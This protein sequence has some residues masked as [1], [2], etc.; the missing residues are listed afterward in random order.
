MGKK[1]NY[2][3]SNNKLKFFIIIVFFIF[4]LIVIITSISK[5]KDDKNNQEKIYIRS[6]NFSTP[7][8]V[9]EYYENEYLSEKTL[10]DDKYSL[11]IYTKFKYDLYEKEESNEEFFYKIIDLIADVLNYQNFK[12]I[13]D[14]K[15]ITIK[16]TCENKEVT[17]ID[18]NGD[19]NYFETMNS[20]L[21]IQKY[22]NE[23][24]IDLNIQSTILN[25][26]IEKDWVVKNINFGQK[27]SVY[28]K[29]DIY[30]DEG[31]EVRIISGKVYNIIF[32]NN[33]TE[34]VINDIKVSD[35]EEKI[36]SILGTPKFESIGAGVFG[37]K[38][39]NIYVFFYQGE[40]S[41]Y[42]VEK[43]YDTLQFIS[44]IKEYNNSNDIKA[45]G[46]DLTYLW[47]DYDEYN[48]DADYVELIYSLKGVKMQ[49]NIE[50][51]NGFILYNNYVGYVSED[52][53]IDEIQDVS[54]TLKRIYIKDSDLVFEAEC[55][56]CMTEY[57][58]YSHEGELSEEQIEMFNRPFE[59]KSE[60]NIDGTYSKIK[61]ISTKKE[62]ADSQL[63]ENLTINSYIWK[64]DFNFIYSIK[65]KGIYLYNC[66]NRKETTIITGNDDFKIN[67]IENNKLKYDEK[68]IEIK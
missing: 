27:D 61:F 10:K 2:N 11:V 12:I 46:N 21:A 65:N 57:F 54:E 55:K 62:Y 39:D 23:T 66:E 3:K 44:L 7:K 51:P 36:K 34:N 22:N 19:T 33:Y 41:I 31:M 48:Y 9:L 6:S 37:Y 58:K 52:K 53:K 68:E 64:D 14:S 43:E 67:S 35:S 29:Y 17:T 24:N 47:T 8:E 49:F 18:I 42:R 16:V 60:E 50:N 45:L 56:R 4:L 63:D 59:M 25:E 30:F 40:I 28:E 1:Y 15:Q 32:T 38:D 26:L 13:D 5:G 20:K